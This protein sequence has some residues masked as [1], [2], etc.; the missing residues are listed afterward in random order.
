MILYHGTGDPDLTIRPMVRSRY[1][2]PAIFAT[3][4]KELARMYARYYALYNPK[5]RK[6]GGYLYE[7][8]LDWKAPELV[9]DLKGRPPA[10]GELRRLFSSMQSAGVYVGQI[11]NVYDW[12]EDKPALRHFRP[13]DLVGIFKPR[14]IF[15]VSLVEIFQKDFD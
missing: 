9:Q 1:G 2:Y 8:E 12:P 13:A 5:F 6:V 3:P 7:L 14:L 11:S 10:L 4:D 15:R